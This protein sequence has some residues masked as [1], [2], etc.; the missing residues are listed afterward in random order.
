MR[1]EQPVDEVES[2]A[3]IRADT[4]E[5]DA[6]GASVVSNRGD[7]LRGF[8]G[9]YG[10]VFVLLILI[11]GFSI[12]LPD[13]FPTSNNLQLML[14]TQAILLV[15]ALG[16]TAPLRCGDFDLSIA[17]TM[18][19]CAAVIGVLTVQHGVDPVVAMVVALAVGLLVGACNGLIVVGLGINP[20]IVTLGTMTILQGL[21]FAITNSEVISGLPDTVVDFSRY[22]IFGLQAMVY[23]GWVLAVV[24][25]Y[26]YRYTP[27]GRFTLF[28]GGNAE[29]ARLAGV[30][31]PRIRFIAFL[32]SGL[33]SGF[34]GVLLAGSLGA[35]N[36]SIGGQYLLQPYAAAFLGAAVIYVG[37]FN[38]VGT[39]VGLYLLVVGSTGLQ[40]LGAPTS[41]TEIF[42]GIALVAAVAFARL[43]GGTDDVPALSWIRGHWQRLTRKR[44][45][46]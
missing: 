2:S 11:I 1:D 36:P 14:V 33:L 15:L 10:L 41:T 3:T 18:I 8:A 38:V 12:R 31:V 6:L 40:L 32:I 43:S 29:A 24:L 34:A 26:V 17:A 42:N 5:E 21:S 35:V 25:W 4:A 44:A 7:R 37:R 13:T 30:P 19:F 16:L 22:R 27:F 39:L 45:A 46:P 20:F 28:V 23:L 9:R